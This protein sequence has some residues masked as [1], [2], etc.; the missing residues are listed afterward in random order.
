MEDLNQIGTVLKEGFIDLLPKLIVAI[1]VLGLGLLLAWI[2]KRLVRR[3]IR[4]IDQLA[5]RRFKDIDLTQSTR[6]IGST[7]FW[8]I[9]LFTFLMVADVLGLTLI[10]TWIDSVLKY[11]PNLIA[12]ILII[13]AATIIG[14]F[15][16][17]LISSSG[18]QLGL[19]YAGTLGKIGQYFILITAIIIAIDQIGIEVSFLIGL[20]GIIMAALLFGAGLAFG[21]G[22]RTSV[23]NILATFYVRKMYKEGDLVKIGEIEGTVTKIDSTT[24]VLENEA[25]QFFIPAKTFS[26]TQSLLIKKK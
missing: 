15:V 16:A 1:L 23:S 4:Y 18:K 17:G 21:I 10:K 13:L 19:S 8:L 5:K 7:F 3:L 22:A 12:A 26:E 14:K 11:S 25:G 24:V 6:F 9:L 20:I 2:V